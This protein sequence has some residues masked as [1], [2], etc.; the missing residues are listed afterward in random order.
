MSTKSLAGQPDTI[1]VDLEWLRN[2]TAAAI[3]RRQAA[4]VLGIDERTIT[5]AVDKGEL[6]SIQAGR[7]V[8]IP[9]LP[10]LRLLGVAD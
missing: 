1:K 10:L 2:S 5:R 6:P 9:R 4:Q 3:S 7:R 8:L